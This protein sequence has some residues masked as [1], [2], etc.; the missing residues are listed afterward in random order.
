MMQMVTRMLQ[1]C[2]ELG[3][4]A[5]AAEFSSTNDDT[6]TNARTLG[7]LNLALSKTAEAAEFLGGLSEEQLAD[8]AL[9]I[10][11]QHIYDEVLEIDK[12]LE[13]IDIER[14]KTDSEYAGA[15]LK[16]AETA[17]SSARAIKVLCVHFKEVLTAY[18]AYLA[19]RT[20]RLA[21]VDPQSPLRRH[22]VVRGRVVYNGADRP[23][24]FPAGFARAIIY[25]GADGY[26][27][28]GFVTLIPKE[29]ADEH[30]DIVER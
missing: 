12:M 9:S 11:C 27:L 25:E 19:A 29:F 18:A 1:L 10:L 30:F 8:P 21:L 23:V 6:R 15:C 26:G 28:E 13:G 17:Y 4:K 7:E 20:R 22:L 2:V 3:I 24:T 16:T 5:S 14:L